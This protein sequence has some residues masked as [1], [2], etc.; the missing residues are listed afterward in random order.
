MDPGSPGSAEAAIAHFARLV[1]TDEP[2]L[3]EAALTMSSVLQPDLDV[4]EWL[5]ALDELAAGCPSPTR[6][7]VAAHLFGSA[8][9]VGDRASYGDW[10]NSCLDHVISIRRGI[11]ITLS[12]VTIE[13]ARRLG[14]PLVGI[15]MPAH[16]LVGDP[17]DPTWFLDAFDGGRVLDRDGCQELLTTTSRGQVPWRESHLDPTPTRAIVA[18]MLNN[19]KAGFV[20]RRDPIRLALVM[21]MRVTVPELRRELPEAARAQAIFN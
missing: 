6:E 13:V 5:A 12:V 17:A 21:R 2:P 7:G 9:F 10:R 1:A 4:V 14:V 8:G 11:P 20:Q 16:F 18:R 19:L 15:G 3:D